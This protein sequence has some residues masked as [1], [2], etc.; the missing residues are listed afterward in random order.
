MHYIIKTYYIMLRYHDE[1]YIDASSRVFRVVNNQILLS[2]T[3]NF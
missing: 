3:T 2:M 1:K